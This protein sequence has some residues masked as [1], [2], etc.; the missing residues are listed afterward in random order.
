MCL[1]MPHLALNSL[2]Y[3]QLWGL[4]AA[5]YIYVQTDADAEE[6]GVWMVNLSEDHPFF[7]GKRLLLCP[8]GRLVFG[9]K[10]ESR[11]PSD[12]SQ[13]CVPLG[14][15]SATTQGALMVADTDKEAVTSVANALKAAQLNSADPEVAAWLNL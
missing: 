8:L 9:T 14:F 13:F 1:D 10:D 12:D 15:P 3:V 5:A 7:F 4:G 6:Q 11:A 2:G